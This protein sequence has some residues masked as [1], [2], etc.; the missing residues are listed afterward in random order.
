MKKVCEMPKLSA[1]VMLESEIDSF[2]SMD[3]GIFT[4]DCEVF[5]FPLYI[6]IYIYTCLMSR[7]SRKSQSTFTNC[8]R[9]IDL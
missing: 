1:A 9:N 6:Y 4:T 3:L 8:A 7:H 5:R 2:S